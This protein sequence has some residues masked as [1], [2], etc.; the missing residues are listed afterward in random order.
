MQELQ[1]AGRLQE[2]L[3]DAGHD[4]DHQVVELE[5]VDAPVVVHVELW[6]ASKGVA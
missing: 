6:W 4:A 2:G 1:V 3:A 5:A